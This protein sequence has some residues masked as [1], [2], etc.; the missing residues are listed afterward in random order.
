MTYI[1]SLIS[2][3]LNKRILVDANLLIL[4]LIG[5][6]DRSQVETDKNT[7]AY[8]CEDFDL[9]RKLLINSKIVVTPNILTEVSN[10]ASSSN[11]LSKQR[12]FAYMGK[13][14]EQ[15]GE[16]YI[17]SNNINKQVLRKFGLTD[18]VI[19]KLAEDKILV[20]TADFPLYGYLS[21][22]GL[23]VINFNHARTEF[24]VRK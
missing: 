14:F 16:V 2:N 5:T 8:T 10:L 7:R 13:L 3:N 15:V 24:M 4:Y 9:L 1:Q 19:H 20:L 21:S 11:E 23:N 22:I 17:P 6:F 12:L 18:S